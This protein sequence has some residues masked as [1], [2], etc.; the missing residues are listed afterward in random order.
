MDH[1]VVSGARGRRATS[2]YT[3]RVRRD[4][5]PGTRS[6]PRVPRAR[7]H[8][9]RIDATQV[10]EGWRIARLGKVCDVPRYGAGAPAQPFDPNQPRYVRITDITDDGHLRRTDA[11]SADPERVEGYELQAGDLLF[12]RSGSVGRS[13][14][15]RPEDGPCVYAGYLIRF[16]ARSNAAVP[17]FLELWTRGQFYR[18]WVASMLRAGAQPN[19]NA[20]EY[21]SLPVAL[22]P[23]AEQTAIAAVLDSIDEAIESADEVIAA[24][25]RLRDALLHELLTRGLPGQHSEWK[26][27]PGVGTIPASWQAVRL[28]DVCGINPCS[29]SLGSESE[30]I[31]YLDL[32]AVVAPGEVA[33]P[34]EINSDRAPSRASPC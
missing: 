9:L 7:L 2:R 21:S 5:G 3:V 31:R 18:R 12:A 20:T 29:W 17:R 27:V 22:P 8:E 25:E 4:R 32:T 34:R 23:L 26:E 10:P 19:I 16:R 11:R 13:Y 33:E 14:L 1:G 30:T 28:G 24:T 6:R 15:Y